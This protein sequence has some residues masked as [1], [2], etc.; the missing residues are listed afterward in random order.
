MVQQ[1]EQS[2]HLLCSASLISLD[3]KFPGKKMEEKAKIPSMWPS[4]EDELVRTEILGEV[5]I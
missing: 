3:F 1:Q 5:R 2:Y 4:C